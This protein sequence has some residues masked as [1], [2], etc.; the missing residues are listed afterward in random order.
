MF[1]LWLIKDLMLRFLTIIVA[2]PRFIAHCA[3]YWMQNN[4][5]YIWWCRKHVAYENLLTHKYEDIGDWDNAT[6]HL[7]KETVW[8]EKLYS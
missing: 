5:I 1:I 8:R 6:R 3:D 2:V 7:I 4:K